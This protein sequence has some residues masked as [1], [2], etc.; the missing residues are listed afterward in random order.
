MDRTAEIKVMVSKT[1]QIKEYEPLTVAIEITRTVKDRGN[2]ALVNQSG[3]LEE[4][5]YQEVD[6]CIRANLTVTPP[7]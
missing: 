5:L 6:R 7:F 3:I 4:E 2:D 1:Q